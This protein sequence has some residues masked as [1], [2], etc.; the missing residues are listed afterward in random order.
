MAFHPDP[1][2]AEEGSLTIPACPAGPLL[3]TRSIFTEK[4]DGIID[5]RESRIS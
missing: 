5:I 4:S 2:A 3:M 1:A